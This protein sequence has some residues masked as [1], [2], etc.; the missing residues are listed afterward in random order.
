MTMYH[1]QEGTKTAVKLARAV[2]PRFRLDLLTWAEGMAA[3]S[4]SQARPWIK[5]RRAV[6]L[7]HN[8]GIA[9]R[10]AT[11]VATSLHAVTWKDRSWAAR[12]GLSGATAAA[13]ASA[14]QGAGIA[15]LGTAVGVPLW[16]V[17]GAGGTF[18]GTLIDE[19]RKLTNTTEASSIIEAEWEFDDGEPMEILPMET[20]DQP[21]LGDA[22][23]RLRAL[24]RGSGSP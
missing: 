17:L 11:H 22:L 20:S 15:A 16:L 7:T 19:L 2:P 13:L 1:D 3:I 9:L 24:R 23:T 18:L 10:V 6:A 5:A 21:R 8:S 4:S 12:L 14:G